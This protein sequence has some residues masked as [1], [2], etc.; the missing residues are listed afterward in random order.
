MP[1]KLYG[2]TEQ[3]L[4]RDPLVIVLICANYVP[5]QSSLIIIH[6]YLFRHEAKWVLS[7]RRPQFMS[8]VGSVVCLCYI[9]I[10]FSFSFLYF[11]Q[12]FP[13]HII[14]PL[15]FIL[16]VLSVGHPAATLSICRSC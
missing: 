11:L 14:S 8:L 10:I 6:I 7:D 12:Y 13:L 3:G 1:H 2:L 5:M 16:Q 9:L 4:N 15:Y